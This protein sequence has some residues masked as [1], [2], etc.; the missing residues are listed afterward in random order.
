MA[1]ILSICKCAMLLALIFTLLQSLL[2]E[3]R[4]IKS[5]MNKQ[6]LLSNE[7]VSPTQNQKSNSGFGSYKDVS[8]ETSPGLSTSLSSQSTKPSS[9][10]SSSSSKHTTA[11]TTDDF[12]PTVPGHSPGVGH[13]L[14]EDDA[15]DTDPIPPGPSPRIERSPSG[16]KP[17]TPGHSPGV[18]H[19]WLEDDAGDADPKAPGPAGTHND[20]S[21]SG[22]KPTT[23]GHSPGVG[24][25]ISDTKVVSNQ[26]GTEKY[27]TTGSKDDFRPTEPGHSPGVGHASQY[28]NAEPNA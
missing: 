28:E 14:S 22:F 1:A 18:G 25:Y 8:E 26:S 3:G 20:H 15:E 17:T 19:F 7:K 6:E 27:S 13:V 2:I 4:P 5:V 21:V 24:H 10:G 12:H 9:L 11:G 23:P 16:F